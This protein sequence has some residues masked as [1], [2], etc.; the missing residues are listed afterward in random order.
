MIY[1]SRE[2]IKLAHIE[3]DEVTKQVIS[4]AAKMDDVSEG[5][6]IRRL[7][8]RFALQPE[9]D[10]GESGVAILAIYEGHEVRARFYGPARV[11]ISDGPLAGQSF[12]TPTGAARAV[13]R[14]YNPQVND[15]R[16]GWTFWQLDDGEGPRSW[17]QT[18]RPTGD[19]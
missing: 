4:F 11:V 16:N 18:L 6:I 9:P 10:P 5:E 19:R 12:K 13:V 15:N 7:V 8:G 2:G 17:L 14:H 3:V 1:V